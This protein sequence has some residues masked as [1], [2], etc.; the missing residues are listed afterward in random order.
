ML[1][2]DQKKGAG[3]KAVFGPAHLIHSNPTVT[4]LTTPSIQKTTANMSAEQRC[5]IGVQN[6]ELLCDLLNS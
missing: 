5:S 2:P 3:P 6:I 4:N 1:Q